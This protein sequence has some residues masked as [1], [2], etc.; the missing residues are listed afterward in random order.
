MESNEAYIIEAGYRESARLGDNQ[1]S[2]PVNQRGPW[3]QQYDTF[4]NRQS[5][6]FSQQADI[7]R[8]FDHT[9]QQHAE[10]QA[11]N[12]SHLS[13]DSARIQTLMVL[14]GT[15]N[16][17]LQQEKREKEYFK[18]KTLEFYLRLCILEPGMP[19][20]HRQRAETLLASNSTPPTFTGIPSVTI[21]S[22]YCPSARIHS[23][24]LSASHRFAPP[25]L[26]ATPSIPHPSIPHPSISHSSISRS[27]IPYPYIPGPSLPRSS[28]SRP[29]AYR[30]SAPRPSAPPPPANLPSAPLPS[31]PPPPADR[32]PAP[33]LSAPRHGTVISS[34]P[35]RHTPHSASPVTASAFHID[36]TIDDI[37]PISHTSQKRKW[38]SEQERLAGDHLRSNILTKKFEWMEPKDQPYFMSRNPY[39]L[40]ILIQR[41]M[42]SIL[43]KLATT[44]LI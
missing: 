13:Q 6:A 40:W 34:T 38:V 39:S 2:V 19:A 27:F 21:P 37:P 5:P 25:P 42:S 35:S 24:L 7:R 26:A 11:S 44:A 15:L 43:H 22:D 12:Q 36:L 18:L 1:I 41:S 29:S 3:S 33:R 16:K 14:I 32:P 30:S 28:A 9:G 20:G 8:Q 23:T 31:A 17:Q 4:S 10:A